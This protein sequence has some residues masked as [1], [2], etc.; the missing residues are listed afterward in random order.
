MQKNISQILRPIM[1]NRSALNANGS[2]FTTKILLM[3]R[4][5]ALASFK[6]RSRCSKGA[7]W[8][9]TSDTS[10]KIYRYYDC[11]LP[12]PPATWTVPQMA[13]GKPVPC[14]SHLI[15]SSNQ[16]FFPW[17][18]ILREA[19]LSHKNTS[20]AA[21]MYEAVPLTLHTGPR[22]LVGPHR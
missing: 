15:P 2:P 18:F 8:K 4:Y 9:H 14:M 17:K 21:I 12:L 19:L 11:I 5:L 7:A 20:F 10:H 16:L 13:D 3:R 22:P 6:S 1:S